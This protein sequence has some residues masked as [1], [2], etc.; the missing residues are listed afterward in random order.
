MKDDEKRFGRKGKKERKS[1][2]SF[3]ANG[4][5]PGGNNGSQGIFSMLDGQCYP[6]PLSTGCFPPTVTKENNTTLLLEMVNQI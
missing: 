2:N 6:M 1:Q 3:S 4:A 5:L